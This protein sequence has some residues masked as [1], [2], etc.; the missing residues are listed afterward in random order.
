VIPHF[1]PLGAVPAPP[2]AARNALGVV[3]YGARCLDPAIRAGVPVLDLRMVRTPGDGFAEVWT[4]GRPTKSGEHRGIVYAHDS[5]YMFCAGRIAPAATYAEPTRNAY[6]TAFELLASSGYRGVFRMWNFIGRINEDNAGGTE[7][8]RDF[9]RGRAEAFESRAIE[10]A[11]IPAATGVGSLGDGIAFYLLA[12]SRGRNTGIENP[13]QTPAYHYPSRYGPKSPRFARATHLRPAGVH[14]TEGR[15]YLSGTAG[16][17]GHESV[18][19][20]DVE[21]QCQVTLDNIAR[22]IGPGNLARYGLE[23]S[24]DLADLQK[25]KVYVRRHAD[26]AAV[27]AMCEK[28]FSP[29]AEVAYLNVDLCRSELLVEIEGIAATAGAPAAASS[30]SRTDCRGTGSGT[31][32]STHPPRSPAG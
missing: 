27:R 20:G 16:I 31:R 18:H 25:I 29:T 9:C 32:T 14:R 3:N 5:E 11:Q 28:A 1:Q 8:Y 23:R 30:I 6:L 22:L 24:R 15:I 13:R 12:A 4:T 10:T 2:P 21:A 19:A 17:L 26:V 7:T